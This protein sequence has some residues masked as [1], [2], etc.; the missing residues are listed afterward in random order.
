M[1]VNMHRCSNVWVKISG[2]P[3]WRAQKALDEAG[4]DYTLA[5]GPV[6]RSRRSALEQLSGQRLYPVIEFEDGS[7][8][9]EE[10]A[11]MV[12]RIRAGKLMEAHSGPDSTPLADGAAD[13]PDGLLDAG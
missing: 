12:E 10:S 9:R 6:R 1:A 5:P 11:A 3:C 7:I 13:P 4:I 8:Y 2:H